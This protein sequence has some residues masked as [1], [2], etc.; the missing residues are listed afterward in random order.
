MR[1]AA[2]VVMDACGV[3][4]LPDAA[5]YGDAGSNTLAHLAEQAGGLRLPTLERLGLGS[6]EPI[7]GVPPANGPGVYGRLHP[8]GPGK[9]STTGHWELMGVVPRRPLP[10]YPDGF[11]ADVMAAI[12]EATGRRFC[13]NRPFS[14]TEVLEAYGPHHLETEEVILYTSADSVMQLAAHVSVLSEE[15]LYAACEAARAVMTGA[16]AVGRVIARP[17]EGSPGSFRRTEGRR[18]YA[19]P[20]PGRSYL[21]ELQAAHAQVHGVGKIPDLFAGVGVDFKYPG[22]TNAAGIAATT[23]LL[24]SVESGLIF[25]NLV[26]TDQVYGHRHDVEGFHRALQEID[27]AAAGWLGL[28]REDDLLILTA[29]HGVDPT[30]P[31]TDH[32]REYA[33]LLATYGGVDGHRHDGPLA[34]VGA[35]VLK[36]VAGREAP[37]LPGKAFVS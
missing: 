29:D 8:L 19:V 31:H 28:L 15:Q 35:S 3:G 22:A 20:P 24:E 33:P 9:E 34:D 17:F 2:V 13:C 4:E 36:W 18:D 30:A 27:A 16:N 26:E 21:Q 10:T 25:V 23:R 5:D 1:R 14:G 7:V 6:I 37:E 12:E 11:P 32:T